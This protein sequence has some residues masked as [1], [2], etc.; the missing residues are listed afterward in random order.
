V[1]ERPDPPDRHKRHRA[2][3]KAGRA[4]CTVEFD[5]AVIDFLIRLGWLLEREAADRKLVGKAIGALI[6]ASA[7]R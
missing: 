5:G 1:L 4:C 7:R 6:A 2:R 3:V